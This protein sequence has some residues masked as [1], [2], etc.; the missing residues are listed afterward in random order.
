MGRSRQ[1]SRREVMAARIVAARAGAGVRAQTIYLPPAVIDRMKAVMRWSTSEIRAG[2]PAARD[3][4]DPLPD[5][6]SDLVETAVWA[7]VLRLEKLHNGAR[8]KRSLSRP[9]KAIPRR[10]A[11]SPPGAD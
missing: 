10:A 2:N 3:A 8:G 11:T 4:V 6:V 1:V 7:E 9:R 5:S